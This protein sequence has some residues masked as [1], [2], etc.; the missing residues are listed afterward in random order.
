MPTLAQIAVDP[1]SGD[2]YGV[3]TDGHLWRGK[4]KHDHGGEEFVEWTSLR[5]EFPRR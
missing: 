2:L 3:D 4:A 5:Q 1:R